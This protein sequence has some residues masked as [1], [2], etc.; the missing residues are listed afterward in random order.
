M[1]AIRKPGLAAGLVAV[2]TLIAGST[3]YAQ[4]FLKPDV[5]Y[6]YA[7][8]DTGDVIEVD[9]AI[10]DG[11]YLYK[12]KLS[13]ASNTAAIVFGEYVLPEGLD[14][15]DEFF[16]KQQIYR[17]RFYV[18]IPY[19]V[20]GDRPESFELQVK[21]QGCADL[22]LCFPPQTWV[23][24]LPLVKVLTSAA[25]RSLLGCVSRPGLSGGRRIQHASRAIG[26]GT[27]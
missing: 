3:A 1:T 27:R 11:Y 16:G 17:E 12:N 22:G 8:V 14:H 13:F 10:E 6:R 20:V 9:W 24:D 5:A 25:G 2:L 23:S 26:G 15:E 4:D 19:I 7:A 18:S 21:S